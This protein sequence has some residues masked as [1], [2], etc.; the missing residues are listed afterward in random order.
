MK[1]KIIFFS[2]VILG[3]I[4][5]RAQKSEYAVVAVRYGFS[6]I[7]DTTQRETPFKENMILFI[8]KHV[9][10]YTSYDALLRKSTFKVLGGSASSESASAESVKP[11]TSKNGTADVAATGFSAAFS[12]VFLSNSHYKYQDEYR[13]FHVN[14]ANG[15]LFAIEEKL[16]VIKWNIS[17]ELREIQGLKCQKATCAFRGRNYEAWFCMDLPYDNGPWKLGGLPGLIVEAYDAKKEV[18]FKFAGFENVATKNISAS[19]PEDVVKTN[20]KAFQ[21]Y[22]EALKKDRNAMKGSSSVDG[23]GVAGVFKI[24]GRLVLSSDGKVMKTLKMN[25]PIELQ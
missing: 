10:R 25:N 24:D 16:P 18:V 20:A 13:I 15:K 2:L 4:S 19:M 11:V 14:Y 1:K 6:H 21:R 5:V 7:M 8:G 17:Q 12:Q 3:C 9:S 22:E 23:A